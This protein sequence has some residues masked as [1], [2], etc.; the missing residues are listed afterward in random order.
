MDAMVVRLNYNGSFDTNFGNAGV[1]IFDIDGNDY[2][3]LGPG[4]V[5]QYDP[6]CS[7]EKILVVSGRDF[8]STF[9]RIFAN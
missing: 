6:Y 8:L 4:G 3:S 2:V 9:A 5:I 1:S 7:C